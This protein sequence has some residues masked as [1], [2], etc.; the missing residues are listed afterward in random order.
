MLSFILF[1]LFCYFCMLIITPIFRGS[2]V[3]K[4]Y[5]GDDEGNRD[6]NIL[7][8]RLNSCT[9]FW[10]LLPLSSEELHPLACF[11]EAEGGE[12]KK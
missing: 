1:S 4:H 2:T 12:C 5:N 9:I 10:L 7:D 8:I 6:A 3:H 11:A